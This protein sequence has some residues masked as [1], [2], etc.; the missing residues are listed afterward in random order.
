MATIDLPSQSSQEAVENVIKSELKTDK[1]K[2]NITYGSKLGDNYIG[3]IYR[4]A[5]TKTVDD[6]LK[7]DKGSN[8]SVILKVPPENPARRDQFFARPCFLRETLVYNEV[9]KTNRNV[10]NNETQ[11]YNSFRYC[12]CFGT[13]KRAKVS[14]F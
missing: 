3:V 2:M 8:V 7:N 6:D 9:T 5:A 10:G 4:V 14:V 11:T 1:F 13:F 12:Q